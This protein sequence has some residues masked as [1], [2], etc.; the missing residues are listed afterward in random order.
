MHILIEFGEIVPCFVL[1]KA[2]YLVAEEDISAAGGY[3]IGC[4]NV[5][6]PSRI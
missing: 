3:R 4:D 6:F 5:A 1:T 2:E